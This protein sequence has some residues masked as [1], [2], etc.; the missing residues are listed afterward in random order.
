MVSMCFW[1]NMPAPTTA[2]LILA[3]K[4]S[5]R[6]LHHDLRFLERID[7]A[8]E[9]HFEAERQVRGKR[10]HQAAQVERALAGRQ[11]VAARL[12]DDLLHLRRAPRMR[13]AKLHIPQRR[14]L[15]V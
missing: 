9:R 13:I 10:T 4:E 14:A 8:R 6:S 2:S 15:Q 12:A 5:P 1:P 11:A 3:A 7:P